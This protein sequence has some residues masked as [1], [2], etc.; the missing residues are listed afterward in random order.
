[1]RNR[2]RLPHTVR[3][4]GDEAGVVVGDAQ[5][6]DPRRTRLLFRRPEQVFPVLA[7]PAVGT[8]HARDIG[9]GLPYSITRHPL[10]RT[11]EQRR[12]V[13]VA[14]IHRQSWSLG[15]QPGLERRDEFPRVGIDGADAAEPGVALGNASLDRRRHRPAGEHAIQERHHL[16]GAL[17]AAE[18]DHED[19]I[20]VARPVVETL[21][22]VI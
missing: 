16:V 7:A 8:E 21:Q 10:H 19:G 18:R 22:V 3:H 9:D 15:G 6:V 4:C 5:L 13:P 1:M 12:R 2:L 11:A 20:V 17:R 14:P